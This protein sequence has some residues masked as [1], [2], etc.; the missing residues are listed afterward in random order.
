MADFKTLAKVQ[1]IDLA[2][3]FSLS[4]AKLIEMLGAAEPIPAAAGETLKQKK[5]TGTLTSTAYT[6]G[7]DI[8]VSTYKTEDV[9]TIS[10]ELKP[11]RTVASAQDIIKRGYENA[12]TAKDGKLLSDIQAVIKGDFVTTLKT[13]TA[14]ATGTD[15][16]KAAAQAFAVLEN[17]AEEN[18]FGAVTPVFFCNPLDFADAVAKTDVYAAFG[19]AYVANFAGLG[20]LIATS[21]VEKGNI[22][23][24]AAQNIKAYYI[25]AAEAVGF[26]FGTDET[27]YIAVQHD[28]ELKNL[29]YNTVAWTGL[30]LFAEYTD[31]VVKGTIAPSE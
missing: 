21:K 3:T 20:N 29:S 13:G 30:T 5:I 7:E 1:D 11:Y 28:A 6:E 2:N 25:P 17:A 23:C 14:T 22:Y 15:L 27:G 8:P 19:F 24:T 9:Q 16:I 26:E 12:V 18:G 31:L 4:A 10:V